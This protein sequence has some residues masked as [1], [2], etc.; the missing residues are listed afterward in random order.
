MVV[1]V[2]V[3]IGPIVQCF[4]AFCYFFSLSFFF[5]FTF[6]SHDSAHNAHIEQPDA[7]DTNGVDDASAMMDD[8]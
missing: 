8:C 1:V 4:H 2:I 3:A 7:R 5:F 6:G